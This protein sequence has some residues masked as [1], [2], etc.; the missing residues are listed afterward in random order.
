MGWSTPELVHGC[1]V[2]RR[3]P[4]Q[5]A[6]SGMQRD[7]EHWEPPVQQGATKPRGQCLCQKHY[8]KQHPCAGCLGLVGRC[9]EGVEASTFHQGGMRAG[10]CG[11]CL[12]SYEERVTGLG[13][14]PHTLGMRLSHS[15]PA[16]WPTHLC[17]TPSRSK[18]KTKCSTPE[19]GNQS[20]SSNILL[21][22]KG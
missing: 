11:V 17:Q 13:L 9:V 2:S 12:E 5:W 16:C 15:I 20:L 18:K 4:L 10:M 14:G 7:S 22:R 6:K 3:H 1:Q 21:L 19:P 8:G